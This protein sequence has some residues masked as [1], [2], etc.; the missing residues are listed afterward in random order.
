[1]GQI[2]LTRPNCET[3]LQDASTEPRMRAVAALGVAFFEV[4]DQAGKLD[5]THRGICLE[6]IYMCQEAIRTAE[7]E[8]AQEEE[9][10][11]DVDA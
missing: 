1:M 7:R 2:H 3:L 9:E 10:D 8:Q 11:E 6:L 4:S 5:G